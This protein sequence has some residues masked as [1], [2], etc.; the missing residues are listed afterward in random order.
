MRVS[1]PGCSHPDNSFRIPVRLLLTVICLLSVFSAHAEVIKSIDIATP[2]WTEITNADGTGLYFELLHLVYDPFG[3]KINFIIVPWMR[4]VSYVD[5]R[6]CDALPGSYNTVDAFFPFYPIDTEHAAVVFKKETVKEWNGQK[7]M[8]NRSVAW[9][10]GYNYHKYLDTRVR[11]VEVNQSDQ[12]WKM[13]LS[14]RVDFL[15]N[16]EQAIN[17]YIEHN[18]LNRDD[19]EIETILIKDLYLRFAKTE[20]SKRLIKIYD[21]RMAELIYSGEIRSLFKKWNFRYPRFDDIG[22]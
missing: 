5:S 9:V 21:Q 8:N 18:K 16:S 11:R 1:L 15:M 10:R 4:A 12:G 19:Y 22:K 6:Q 2:E 7:S 3:I 13:L 14:D 20:K 17:K